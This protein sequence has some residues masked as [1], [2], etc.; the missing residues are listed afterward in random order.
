[1]Y[2]NSIERVSKYRYKI[3][4]DE[5]TFF[6]YQSDLRKYKLESGM[7]LNNE[8]YERIRKE[9]IIPGAKKKAME[10]LMRSDNSEKE[11]RF[12]LGMKGFDDTAVE[13]AVNYVKAFRY[14]DD[15]RYTENYINYRGKAKSLKQIKFELLNKGIDRETVEGIADKGND[16]A[17][18][19]ILIRRKRGSIENFD[20]V[21]KR[22]LYAYL[23]RKGFDTELISAKMNEMFN[24]ED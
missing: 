22:K 1:M 2:I 5:I 19:E 12:K 16:E 4:T 8:L 20:E 11:L 18:I 23:Y 9:T 17:A 24:K 14:I 7:E 13:E 6:L 3:A 21:S 10:L 15:E